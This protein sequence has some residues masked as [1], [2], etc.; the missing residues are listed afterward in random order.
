MMRSTFHRLS[1]ALALFAIALPATAAAQVIQRPPRSTGGLF[2]GADQPVDPNR[3]RSTLSW[4][5]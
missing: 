1:L 4:I 5:P 2:G 3:T